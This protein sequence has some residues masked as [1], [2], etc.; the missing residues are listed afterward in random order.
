MDTSLEKIFNDADDYYNGDH[1][2][3]YYPYF[4]DAK[5]LFRIDLEFILGDRL[6]INRN[7]YE[8]ETFNTSKIK[9]YFYSH[10]K[11]ASDFG[12]RIRL[13]C[14]K[15][16]QRK[17]KT[18]K[19]E[20][21]ENWK[22]IDSFGVRLDFDDSINPMESVSVTDGYK[23]FYDD[24]SEYMHS[25]DRWILKYAMVGNRYLD[26]EKGFILKNVTFERFEPI[27]FTWND[28][29]CRKIMDAGPSGCFVKRNLSTITSF[30]YQEN[31]CTGKDWTSLFSLV[32]RGNR[33]NT[34]DVFTK[35]HFE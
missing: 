2:V 5:E 28:S 29:Y 20:S 4:N 26:D 19:N 12:T 3:Y 7:K 27:G 18:S 21:C 1:S 34:G 35:T 15:P 6:I 16:I 17:A 25:S 8:W 32:K 30:N 10:G 9:T 11:A 14:H 33:N 24:P 31:N 22:L 23:D 13:K